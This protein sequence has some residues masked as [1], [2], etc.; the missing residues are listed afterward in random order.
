MDKVRKQ[1]AAID[2][3]ERV[4]LLSHCLRPS[5]RCPGKFA[6]EGL[7]CP[8]PCEEHCVVGRLRDAAISLG[9]MG[10]CIAAGGSMALKYVLEHRPRG[11]VAVACEKELAE[12]VDAV[13]SKSEN[14]NSLPVIVV[15]PLIND[16][17]VDTEVDEAAALEIISLVNGAVTAQ[18]KRSVQPERSNKAVDG[19][20]NG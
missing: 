18:Q 5:K 14:E 19:M 10:V 17:C 2:P 15:V 11:I 13:R 1:L 9:Y 12:G 7:I 20:A 3:K 16:G 4:L 8:E 6:K